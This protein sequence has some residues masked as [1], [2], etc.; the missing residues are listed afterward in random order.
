M[1]PD[2]MEGEGEAE[3]LEPQRRPRAAAHGRARPRGGAAA[4]GRATSDLRGGG[5][6]SS[7]ASEAL[8]A[9]AEHLQAVVFE[10]PEGKGAIDDRNPLSFGRWC[11]PAPTRPYLDGQICARGR[12]AAQPGGLQARPARGADR[13]DPDEIGRNHAGT[14]GLIGDA[15][16]TLVEL[17]ERVRAESAPR[18][19]RQGELREVHQ[20]CEALMTQEPQ[21]SILRSLRAAAPRTRSSWVA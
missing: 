1:P 20:A 3:L 18:S 4:E 14:F 11:S 21:A 5:V 13:R 2:T 16:A 19:S 8:T 9:L 6:N 15:H 7:G 12:V 10:S 17:L